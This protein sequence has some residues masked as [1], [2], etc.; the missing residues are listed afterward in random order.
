MAHFMYLLAP[1]ILSNQKI[2]RADPFVNPSEVMK[3][4][5]FRAENAIFFGKTNKIIFMYL[6]AAFIVQNFKNNG[7]SGSRVMRM[8][9]F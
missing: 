2:L 9:H 6:F 8:R 1:L 4:N 3:S 5:H 7:Y